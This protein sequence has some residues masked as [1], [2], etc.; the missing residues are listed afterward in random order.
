M[1]G[2]DGLLKGTSA[3]LMAPDPGSVTDGPKAREDNQ[4]SG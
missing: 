3:P 2:L 4:V 1:H